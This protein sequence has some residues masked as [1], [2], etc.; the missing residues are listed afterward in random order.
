MMMNAG[1]PMWT[2][3]KARVAQIGFKKLTN[4]F[5]TTHLTKNPQNYGCSAGGGVLSKI[6]VAIANAFYVV[7]LPNI[8]PHTKYHQNTL[9]DH[10]NFNMISLLTQIAV[11]WI[12][13]KVDPERFC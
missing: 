13:K 3:R 12:L 8:S 10:R 2:S 11:S 4:W 6:A 1:N 9:K 5:K 7:F